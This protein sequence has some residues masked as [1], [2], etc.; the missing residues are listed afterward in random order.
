MAY[1][2]RPFILH[3]GM[4]KISCTHRE[5]NEEVLQSHRGKKYSTQNKTQD[6]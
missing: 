6:G 1:H 2:L 3:L 4:G 5:E